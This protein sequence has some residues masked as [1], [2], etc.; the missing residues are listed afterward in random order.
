MIIE[1][2]VER[3]E[4]GLPRWPNYH[5]DAGMLIDPAPLPKDLAASPRPKPR[6]IDL[7]PGWTIEGITQFARCLRAGIE[8][9]KRAKEK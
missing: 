6:P 2:F 3:L 4:D 9:A 5:A 1:I 7:G 8:E